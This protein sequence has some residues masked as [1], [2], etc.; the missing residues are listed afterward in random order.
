M[1]NVGG[2]IGQHNSYGTATGL[3]NSGNVK[4]LVSISSNTEDNVGG[5]VGLLSRG[6]PCTLSFSSNSGTVEGNG[7]NVGGVVGYIN[8][9]CIVEN[10]YNEGSVTSHSTNIN[11]R[12]GG[13]IGYARAFGGGSASTIKKTVNMGV[14]SSAA[15]NT[16]AMIGGSI[17]NAAAGNTNISDNYY[18]EGALE[19][20]GS[21][22]GA[23]QSLDDL[24][25]TAESL[26]SD[27]G[28]DPG[29]KATL[30]SAIDQIIEDED[31]TRVG[32]NTDSLPDG[33]VGSAYGEALS[34]K[35]DAPIE[36][37]IYGGSLPGGLALSTQGAISGV[38]AASGSFSFTVKADNGVT[39]DTKQYTVTIAPAQV[40][41]T[42]ATLPG[43]QVGE[44]YSASLSAAGGAATAWSVVGGSLPGG[45]S[46]S[47]QGVVSGSPTAAGAFAFTVKAD[48]GVTSDTETYSVRIALARVD[49][50]TASLPNG[51]AG[52]AYV[53]IFEAAGGAPVTWTLEGGS[54]PDGL[55]LH[56]QGVISGVPAREGAFRFTLKAANADSQDTESF[57][58]LISEQQRGPS[59]DQ[60]Q[61]PAVTP[62]EMSNATVK[63][64]AASAVWTGRQIK[65]SV[66]VTLGGKVLSMGA[67]Y[68]VSYGANKNIGV[69]SVTVTAGSTAYAGAKT[70]TFRIDPKAVSFKKLTPGKGQLN[71]TWGRAAAAQKITGYQLQYRVKGAAKWSAA[72]SV[73]AKSVTYTFKKLKKGKRY[74]VRIRAYKS[75]KSGASKGTY[76]GAWSSKT[77]KKL[78]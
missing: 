22:F 10:C 4:S 9:N 49:I 14:V 50:T 69:G 73:G 55:S 56:A 19:T 3:T 20:T 5:V 24:K 26:F 29:F 63:V 52:A 53:A 27:P 62:V 6:A 16:S 54:L 41:I 35:G 32:I 33:R 13:V 67:D 30:V 43:G 72:K 42:T 77:S 31:A 25:D 17:G 36:W 2:V 34:A 64:A 76:Y 11:A 15:G 51:Q 74:E 23:A 47:A 8:A 75:I 68:T 12:A 44:S 21:A 70:V 48:N 71:A 28:V 40:D 57:T 65:P 60:Q 18:W 58:I 39:S 78:R 45:L 59:Q 7:V 66:T 38:P 37:T 46:L 61:P 1:R